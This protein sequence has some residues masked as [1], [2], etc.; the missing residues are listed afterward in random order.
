M[1]SF[2]EKR[3]WVI[4]LSVLALGAL[5]VLAVGLRDVSFR[6]AQAFGRDEAGATRSPPFNLIDSVLAIPPQKQLVVWVLFVLMFVLI[7]MVLSPELRKRLIRMAIRV[8]VTYWALYILFTRYRDVLARIILNPNSA[9]GD[10]ASASNAALP[11]EFAPP[12]TV[13]L[14]SYLVSFGIVL[15]LIL[16]ARKA[17]EFWKELNASSAVS[18]LQKI[19]RIAR[20]SLGD[21]SAGRDSTDVIMNCYY[22]MSDV[23]SEKRRLDRGAAV[24]PNEFAVTLEQA[25][26]PGDAVRRLTR[27]FESAR[28]GDRRSNAAAVNEAVACLT[29]IIQHCGETV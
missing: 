12:Q 22:R 17:Y 8:A 24:T 20:S 18:P 29:T 6:G 13:S 28:Y 4:V 5:T 9:E 1:R 27:L 15:L 7:G 23:V 10:S 19:A 16:F 14:A 21:L 11:P 3:I 2:F 25:G 26:L